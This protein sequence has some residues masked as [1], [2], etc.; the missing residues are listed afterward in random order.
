MAHS[1]E[2][3]LNMHPP[4][5]LLISEWPWTKSNKTLTQS[6]GNGWFACIFCHIIFIMLYCIIYVYI[7]HAIKLWTTM[8]DYFCYY[9]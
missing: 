2:K 9:C 8:E 5:S 7:K 1:H 3:I 6:E 4:F